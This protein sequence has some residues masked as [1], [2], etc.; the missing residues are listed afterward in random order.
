MHCHPFNLKLLREIHLTHSPHSPHSLR[1]ELAC[2]QLREVAGTHGNE[3]VIEVVARVVQL[4]W[5]ETSLRTAVI[6][7]SIRDEAEHAGFFAQHEGEI[8][9]AHRR[10]LS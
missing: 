9:P 3:F 2:H 5:P 6:A 10:L 4:A 1:T 8:F 7:F